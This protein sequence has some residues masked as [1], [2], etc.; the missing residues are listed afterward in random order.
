[1]ENAEWRTNEWSKEY[2]V[3]VITTFC[4]CMS[5]LAWVCVSMC[6]LDKRASANDASAEPQ[7]LQTF[8]MLATKLVCVGHKY[9]C[10]G[11]SVCVFLSAI[12]LASVL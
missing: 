12:L 1:M 5:V 4:M 8:Q 3:A 11:S 2:T 6:V 10:V 9:V 7:K